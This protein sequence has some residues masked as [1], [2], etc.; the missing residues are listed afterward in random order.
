MRLSVL[1]PGILN[2]HLLARCS[3]TCQYN[4]IRDEHGDVGIGRVRRADNLCDLGQ[5]DTVLEHGDEGSQ[6]EAWGV[7]EVPVFID[8][9]PYQ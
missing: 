9:L 1:A 2:C 3:T 8:R 7:D 4:I 5:N 6:G